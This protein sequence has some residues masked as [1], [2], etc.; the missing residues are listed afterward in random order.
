MAMHAI[1]DLGERM[2]IAVLNGYWCHHGENL[3]IGP[4]KS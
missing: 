2:F 1:M 4:S 3:C